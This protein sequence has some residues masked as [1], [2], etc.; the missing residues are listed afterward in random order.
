MFSKINCKSASANIILMDECY[1][2][3][4]DSVLEL[5]VPLWFLSHMSEAVPW[6]SS[7]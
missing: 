2:C 6:A 7:V 5:A 4:N 3:C 1:N